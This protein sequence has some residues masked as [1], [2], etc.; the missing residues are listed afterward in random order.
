MIRYAILR[1]VALAA[2]A[3]AALTTKIAE[4]SAALALY[5]ADVSMATAQDKAA[6]KAVTLRDAACDAELA[7]SLLC[8]DHADLRF[9]INREVI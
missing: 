5:F 4:A 8:E 2:R 6:N 3:V 7:Y 9:A 1:R